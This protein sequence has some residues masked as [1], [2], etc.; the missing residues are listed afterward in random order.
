ME[1][2]Y[3]I[4]VYWIK[5]FAWNSLIVNYD[6][7]LK[8]TEKCDEGNVDNDKRD[9]DISPIILVHNE[10]FNIILSFKIISCLQIPDNK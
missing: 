8:K 2:K 3:S 1:W 4:S 10:N 9:E 5:G 6:R 7:D